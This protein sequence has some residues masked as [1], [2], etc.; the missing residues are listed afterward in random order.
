MKINDQNISD[1]LSDLAS[2]K[3]APGGGSASALAGAMA[4]ALVTMVARLTLGK[5]KYQDV[6]DKVAKIEKEADCLVSKL[7]ELADQDEK[8]YQGVVDAYRQ[9][10]DYHDTNHDS[11]SVDS[12]NTGESVIQLAYQEAA[13][14]PM[15]T[16]RESLKV[17]KMAGFL[18]DHGN[19]NAR[20]DAMVAMELAQAAIYGALENVRINLG[21]LREKETVDKLKDQIEKYFRRSE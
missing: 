20:S 10:K 18:V 5:D 1:F 21:Y 4:A 14:V 7:L 11:R 13:A 16:A 9:V 6:E 17:F 12:D 3:P 15:Q 8:A 19:R 2:K